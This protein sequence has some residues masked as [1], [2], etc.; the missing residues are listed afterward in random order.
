MHSGDS[1]IVC[2]HCNKPYDKCNCDGA[3]GRAKEQGLREP[4]KTLV[5]QGDGS[6]E[7]KWED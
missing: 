7:W 4:T 2:N 6:F 3:L 1:V 5:E